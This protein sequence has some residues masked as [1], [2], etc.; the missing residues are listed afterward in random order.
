MN[1]SDK[2][3]A[4]F[5]EARGLGY[6]ERAAVVYAINNGCRRYNLR[7]TEAGKLLDCA[8]KARA[9]MSPTMALLGAV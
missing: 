6:A 5:A 8:R 9:S 2:L 7:S 3:L 4:L 1:T